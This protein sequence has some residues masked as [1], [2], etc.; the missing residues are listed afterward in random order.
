MKVVG[1]VILV[2]L[3]FQF[4]KYAIPAFCRI[5]AQAQRIYK[6]E[7]NRVDQEV[8]DAIDHNNDRNRLPRR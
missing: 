3:G 8:K 7:L 2:L 6:D 4:L 5:L 1:I